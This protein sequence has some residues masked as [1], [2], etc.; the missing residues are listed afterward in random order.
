[1]IWKPTRRQASYVQMPLT[2]AMG[3]CAFK[4]ATANEGAHD[5]FGSHLSSFD[6]DEEAS[7]A[8]MSSACSLGR[9]HMQR[10]AVSIYSVLLCF[11]LMSLRPNTGVT[12]QCLTWCVEVN[13]Q[14]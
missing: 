1:M 2:R 8:P 14:H 6:L 4:S 7:G 10:Y 13:T 11:P 9:V 12:R 5:Q 3:V